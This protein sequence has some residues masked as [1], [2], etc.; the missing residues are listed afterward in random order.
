MHKYEHELK[1]PYYLLFVPDEQE[2]TL[3]RHSGPKYLSVQPDTHGRYALPEVEMEIALLDGWVRFWYQGSLLPLPAELERARDAAHQ[4]AE[5]EA[6]RAAEAEA[7]V[8]RLRKQL[9]ALQKPKGP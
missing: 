3:Y 9:E 5:K 8:E 4:R 2:L 7:E 6:R 1:V